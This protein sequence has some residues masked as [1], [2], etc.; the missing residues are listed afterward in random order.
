MLCPYCQNKDTRVLETRFNKA[1][2][3]RRRR[4]CTHCDSRFSTQEIVVHSMPHVQKKDG[5]KEPFN[6]QKLRKGIQSACLKRPVSLAQI[7]Q[8][9]DKISNYT[10]QNSKKEVKS[11]IIGHMLMRELKQLDDVA[12]VRFASV[13]R[14][15]A[16]V[17]EFVKSLSE[18]SEKNEG[19]R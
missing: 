10:A 18:T 3:L 9:V 6:K 7:E 14:T 1:G 5:R 13:Y 11:E 4:H 15:F 19:K 17:N 8:V 2:A 12:Y 16:D